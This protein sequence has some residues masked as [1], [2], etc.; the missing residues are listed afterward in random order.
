MIDNI[1][2]WALELYRTTYEDDTITKED[3]FYYTYGILHHTG[4]REKYQAFLVRGIP[5]I[6]MAPD[7]HAFC[8]AGRELAHM[9][10]N[11][12]SDVTPRYDLGAPLHPIPDAPRKIT[13]G[14]KKNDGT[15]TRDATKLYL[16]DTLVY[17]NLPHT[18]YKV[19]GL[20]PIGWFAAPNGIVQV[21]RYSYREDPVTG[22][23]N[24][25]LKGVKSE[26][27]RGM[28]ERLVYIGVQSDRIIENLPE[29]FEGMDIKQEKPKQVSMDSF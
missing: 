23:T 1:T 5:N 7:F 3:I 6:P 19:N 11:F 18:D 27:V 12:D 14:K 9:H 8:T 26:E 22:I 28:I 16:D 15:G 13:F 4:F 21:S 10:L 17:D 24:Y 29:K 20:T 25:P 2:D